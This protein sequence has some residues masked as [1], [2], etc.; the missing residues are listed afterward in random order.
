MSPRPPLSEAPGNS[1]IDDCWQIG[2]YR[3]PFFDGDTS[4]REE[5]RSF[6]LVRAELVQP[7]GWF[8]GRVCE[9]DITGCFGVV[10]THLSI[11]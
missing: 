9:R 2:V 3:K 8:A 1:L 10:E 7:Y 5:H 4:A 6:G 11:W